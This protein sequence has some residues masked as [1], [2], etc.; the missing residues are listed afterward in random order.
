MAVVG[1][2]RPGEIA[3]QEAGTAAGLEPNGVG[4]KVCA[5]E[6]VDSTCLKASNACGE[7]CQKEAPGQYTAKQSEQPVTTKTTGGEA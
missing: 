4:N 6:R 2:G 1:R 3:A 7:G 5:S